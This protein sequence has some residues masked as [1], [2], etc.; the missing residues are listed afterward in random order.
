MPRGR[1]L[2]IGVAWALNVS[3]LLNF[4]ELTLIALWMRE[5]RSARFLASEQ[6]RATFHPH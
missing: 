5:M 1:F 4:V 3:S 2:E 6:F